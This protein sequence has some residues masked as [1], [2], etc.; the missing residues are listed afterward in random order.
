MR[1]LVTGGCGFIGG[2][3]V[4]ELI[5]RNH[6]VVVVDDL[7]A[8]ENDYFHFNKKAQYF[9]FDISVED[10]S[11]MFGKVD[12]IFHFAARS[13]IQD[14]DFAAET[15]KMTKSQILSQA[16]TSMLAQANASK[17]NLLALLQG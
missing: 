1:V 15:S 17:Q 5:K 14:A 11:E 16:A 12:A 6:D 8:P 10:Q 13:R 9:N 4:D 2:H 7:S 3:T